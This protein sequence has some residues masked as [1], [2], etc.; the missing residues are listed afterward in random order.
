MSD[1]EQTYVILYDISS[2]KRWRRVYK[3]MK[4]YGAWLQLSAFQCR[5]TDLRRAELTAKASEIIKHDEDSFMILDLGSSENVEIK[6]KTLGKLAFEPIQPK[7][8][9]F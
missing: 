4:G 3:L 7:A 8:Q 9:I 2:S 6:V 1:Q 5:L